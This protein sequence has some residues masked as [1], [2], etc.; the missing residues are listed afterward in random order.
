MARFVLKFHGSNPRQAD[1]DLI[2]QTDGVEVLDHELRGAMLVEAPP[3]AAS[4]LDAKL[5]DWTVASETGY[6]AP[7]PHRERTA[8]EGPG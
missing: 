4:Q 7:G 8:E 5:P 3:Q 1:V 6:P 2:A